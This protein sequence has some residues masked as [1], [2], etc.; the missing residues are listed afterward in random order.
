[1][2]DNL[3]SPESVSTSG[4]HRDGVSPTP[5]RVENVNQTYHVDA[6]D[7][8]FV[9]LFV[10]EAN[11]AFIVEAVNSY[12]ALIQERDRLLAENTRLRNFAK[13]IVTALDSAARALPFSALL[14]EAREALGE[15]Q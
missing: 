14:R 7:G 1:M 12:E 9:A 2:A 3:T 8:G 10:S 15:A 4:G 13:W 11:A 5:W 6:A